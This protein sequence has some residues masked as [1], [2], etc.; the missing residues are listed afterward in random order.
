MPKNSP[1]SP[2]NSN[3]DI[4][5]ESFE[6]L[7]SSPVFTPEEVEFIERIMSGSPE[8]RKRVEQLYLRQP[9]DTEY[10]GDALK[11]F[12]DDLWE[13]ILLLYEQQIVSYIEM[14]DV[15]VASFL[16]QH[17]VRVVKVFK[18]DP[19]IRRRFLALNLASLKGEANTLVTGEELARDIANIVKKSL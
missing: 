4:N 8:W 18:N 11:I 6:S 15:K 9:R 13:Y 16:K 17:E 3:E 19:E 7:C 14:T 12:R 10:F 1:E 2:S 5:R